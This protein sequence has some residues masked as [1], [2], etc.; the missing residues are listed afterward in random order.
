MPWAIDD[1]FKISGNEAIVGFIMRNTTLSAHDEVAESLTSSARGLSDVQWYCPNVHAYAYFVLY[2][3]GN[4]I[5]GIAFGQNALAYR[6]PLERIVEAVA[7]GGSVC[8]AIG[9]DWILW[10]PWNTTG[11]STA[12]WCKVA[13]DHA[14]KYKCSG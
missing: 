14:V 7:E 8:T 5:F 3:R 4:R 11:A 1:R 9:D 6:L 13:H 12:K 2:T 10:D